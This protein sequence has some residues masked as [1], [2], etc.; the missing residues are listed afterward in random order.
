M[1]AGGG[2]HLR[3]VLG[4]MKANEGKSQKAGGN[5][6]QANEPWIMSGGGELGVG[7]EGEEQR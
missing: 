4:I 7:E 3:K 1:G 2:G 6:V 5:E